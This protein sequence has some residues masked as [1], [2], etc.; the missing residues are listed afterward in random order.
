MFKSIIARVSSPS[1]GTTICSM[2]I[3]LGT[4]QLGSFLTGEQ[5]ESHY[6]TVASVLHE[7]G[8]GGQKDCELRYRKVAEISENKF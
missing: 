8:T 2:A 1:L 4:L 6:F 3:P 7:K 5:S